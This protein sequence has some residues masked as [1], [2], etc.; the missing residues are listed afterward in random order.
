MCDPRFGHE[1][2]HTITL[3]RECPRQCLVVFS[4]AAPR[5]VQH[6]LRKGSH[7]LPSLCNVANAY[8]FFSKPLYSTAVIIPQNTPLVKILSKCCRLIE[9]KLLQKHH[10]KERRICNGQAKSCRNNKRSIVVAKPCDKST[11]HKQKS[12][13]KN[14]SALVFE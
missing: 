10:T 6:R 13:R 7:Q 1:F 2:P 9:N 14:P 11:A 12:T 8:Y 3:S 4:H 5:W